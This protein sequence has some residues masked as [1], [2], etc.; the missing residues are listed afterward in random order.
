MKYILTI[1]FSLA[2]VSPAYAFESNLQYVTTGAGSN[3]GSI[4]TGIEGVVKSEPTAK[5][6]GRASCREGV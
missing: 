1:I 6:I 4:S 5:Q 3:A 2:L